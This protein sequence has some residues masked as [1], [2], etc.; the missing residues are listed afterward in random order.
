MRL[1]KDLPAAAAARIE[2]KITA[3]ELSLS[4]VQLAESFFRDKAFAEPHRAITA[5]EKL[6]VL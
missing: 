3:G 1:L 4:N 6:N 2:T 5:A